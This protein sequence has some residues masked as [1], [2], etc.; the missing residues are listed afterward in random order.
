MGGTPILGDI[1]DAIRDIGKTLLVQLGVWLRNIL[2]FIFSNFKYD[3]PVHLLTLSCILFVIT[4]MFLGLF[5]AGGIG[6]GVYSDIVVGSG[7]VMNGTGSAGSITSGMGLG[8]EG[9]TPEDTD[10]DGIPDE[11][12]GDI[13]GDG[14]PNSQDY[15]IDGDGILNGDDPTPCGDYIDE[16]TMGIPMLCGNGVCDAFLTSADHKS[17]GDAEMDDSCSDPNLYY[18]IPPYCFGDGTTGDSITIT[19]IGWVYYN[20]AVCG[21]AHLISRLSFRCQLSNNSIWYI[22]TSENCPVDCNPPNETCYEDYTCDVIDNCA[23]RALNCCPTGTIWAGQCTD[24]SIT[25]ACNDIA[26]ECIVGA[27]MTLSQLRHVPYHCPCTSDTGCIGDFGG[28]TCCPENTYH[29]GFCYCYLV[30][31]NTG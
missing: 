15:D 1:L 31:N 11:N 14:I 26:G 10:G 12:D 30:C 23:G 13:D 6:A 24:C 7:A 2:T 19:T 27:G 5:C 9:G 29:E 8:L 20:R 18:N 21:E 17:L 28:D 4:I 25:W 22:E 16:C 3:N